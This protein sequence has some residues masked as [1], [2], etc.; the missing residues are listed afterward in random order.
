METITKFRGTYPTLDDYLAVTFTRII[1]DGEERFTTFED[2]HFFE[3]GEEVSRAYLDKKYG[4]EE[5]SRITLG[6]LFNSH[7]VKEDDGHLEV[8]DYDK[9]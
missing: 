4:H 6:A 7:E 3:G 5:A 1:D 9:T 8:T 2:I